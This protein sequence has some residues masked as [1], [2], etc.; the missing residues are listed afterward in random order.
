MTVT[1]ADIE[2]VVDLVDE[3]AI[4]T[5]D[6]GVALAPGARGRAGPAQVREPPAH[7]LVQDPRRLRPPVPAQRGGAGAR[8]GGGVGGQPRAGGRAGGADARHP[9]DGVHARWGRRSRRPTPPA[10][11]APRCASTASTSPRRWSPPRSSPTRPARSSS[12]PST[13]PTS[14]RGRAPSGWRSLEQAPE[15]ATVLVPTGGGGLLAGVAIA[16]KAKR[17][18]VRVDR[19]PGRGGRRL[20]GVAAHGS[21]G[22]PGED[23]HDGRRHRR[24]LPGRRP[25][26]GHPAPR[27]RGRHRLRGVDVTG[28]GDAARAGQDGRRAVGRGCGRGDDGP[29]AGGSVRRSS[30]CSPAATSTRCCSAT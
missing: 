3:V 29:A 2:A 17:P 5:L 28:A 27:R 1:L 14:W 23:D 26:R 6:G 13:T 10:A 11:T 22:R 15:A 24:G 20:P 4:R 19:G 21:P 12:T 16:V 9:G 18:D 30:P 8:R 7:R 25:V